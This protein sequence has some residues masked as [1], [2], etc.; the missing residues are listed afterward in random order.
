MRRA[1]LQALI[2]DQLRD[3]VVAN[4]LTAGDRLP[5]ERDLAVRLSV[6]RPTLRVALNWLHERGALRRVQGGGTYLESG[7]LVAL[8]QGQIRE[9]ADALSL[10]EL[11][12]TRLLLEPV[13]I[14]LVARRADVEQLRALEADLEKAGRET[15]S[16]DAWRQHD[17]HFH[18]RLAQLSGNR[19]LADA[20]DAVLLHLPQVWSAFQDEHRIM[21]SYE[22]HREILDAL[23]RGDAVE[24][25]RRMRQ[26]LRMFER[27]LGLRRP[28]RKPKEPTPAL[29][30]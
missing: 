5:S 27:T 14:R 30:V 23:L 29:P 7:F 25:A 28:K 11:A 20:V 6:S 19:V 18:T 9:V 1:S 16:V 17:L 4:G 3:Y 26:H 12:E 10:A 22:E 24:S 8:A 15:E 2:L 13:L 21:R